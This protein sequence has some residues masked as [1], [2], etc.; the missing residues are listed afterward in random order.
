MVSTIALI[1]RHFSRLYPFAIAV[2]CSCRHEVTTKELVSER[3]KLHAAYFTN[4]L[5]AAENIFFSDLRT[6][7][8]W[9]SNHV[10]GIEF[11]ACQA[12]D[13]QGLFF[14]YRKAHG[15]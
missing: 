15:R 10:S 6:L 4:D 3:S 8:N 7:S 14:I 1:M 13:H 12:L 11:N 9:Q 2:V 5:Q